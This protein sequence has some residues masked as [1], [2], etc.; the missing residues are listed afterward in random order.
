V[1]YPHL[2]E[3]TFFTEEPLL[4]WKAAG[5][6]G[7]AGRKCGMPFRRNEAERRNPEKPVF[8]GFPQK[9]ALKILNRKMR[10]SSN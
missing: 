7:A 1:Q 6:V 8:C 5:I 2:Q 4:S 10:R 9:A 3:G